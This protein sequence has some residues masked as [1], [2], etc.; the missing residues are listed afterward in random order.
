MT[1]HPHAVL[2]RE[3]L[4]KF[5][6]GDVEASMAMLDDDVVW[7]QIGES[8]PLRGK[9]ALLEQMQ[10]LE[11]VEWDIDV[12]DALAND[13]HTVLLA[14]ATVRVGDQEFSYR[15]A[16]ILHIEEG[17]V[18]ERWAFSDDTARINAFFSQFQDG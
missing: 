10:A 18:K 2:Y 13:E 17:K 15:T 6:A 11:G 12:H 4:E 1:D 16:E 14:N 3:A 9:A 8:E 5:Q 7:W